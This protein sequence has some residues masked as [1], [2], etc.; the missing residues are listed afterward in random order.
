LDDVNTLY[1]LKFFLR[2]NILSFCIVF[3][4]V[5]HYQI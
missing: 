1:N 4:D 5:L 3:G 2:I